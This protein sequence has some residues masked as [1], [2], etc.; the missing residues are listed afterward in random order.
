MMHQRLFGTVLVVCGF[1]SS[2]VE[3]ACPKAGTTYTHYAIGDPAMCAL[4]GGN[5]DI[6]A[7]GPIVARYSELGVRVTVRNQLIEMRNAGNEVIRTIVWHSVAD[8]KKK[9]GPLHS[10]MTADELTNLRAFAEDVAASGFSQWLISFG[11]QGPNNMHCKK[12]KWGDCYAPA[13][14][15]VN[16]KFIVKA[17]EVVMNAVNGRM[18]MRF[19]LSNEA[20]TDP[21]LPPAAIENMTHGVKFLIQHYVARYGAGDMEVSCSAPIVP[22]LQALLRIYSDLRVRPT[23]LDIHVYQ[24]GDELAK[25]LDFAADAAEQF[26]ATL[27]IG[28]MF[29]ANREQAEI[30]ARA[31]ANHPKANIDAAFQW[32]LSAKESN[33]KERCHVDVPPPYS[34]KLLHESL[35][36]STR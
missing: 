10:E 26:G 25:G 2:I 13:L 24:T 18:Q 9:W 15:E 5:P 19:D 33:T 21:H 4:P 7:A 23:H 29:Y 27:T 16:W 22:R 12:E 17:R 11:P 31:S 8:P 14:E 36:Q 6:L 1:H 20:C 34:A 3:A 32:P 30:I 35:C 28:E